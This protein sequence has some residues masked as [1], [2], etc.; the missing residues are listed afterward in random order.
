MSREGFDAAD[1]EALERS[2][3][4]SSVLYKMWWAK[5]FTGFC[6]IGIQMMRRRKWSEVMCP[7]CVE[8][9]ERSTR[10][11]W[12]C[13]SEALSEH[14]KEEYSLFLSWLI[15]MD[16]SPSV[17]NVFRRLLGCKTHGWNARDSQLADSASMVNTINVI[18][19]LLPL[20]WSLEQAAHLGGK[21][22]EGRSWA[23]KVSERLMSIAHGL[24]TVQNTAMRRAGEFG[25]GRDAGIELEDKIREQFSLG[26]AGM[27]VRDTF[28]LDE[29]LNGLLESDKHTSRG[30]LITVLLARGNREAAAVESCRDYVYY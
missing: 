13:R 16:T 18:Q 7:C 20:S 11:L 23:T 17:V 25:M 30:W 26:T 22:I 24:W 29:D 3:L 19:G 8:V 4:I 28:L 6:S 14:R 2:L 5:D 12:E 15:T 10:H 21:A 1:W 27:G 9:E